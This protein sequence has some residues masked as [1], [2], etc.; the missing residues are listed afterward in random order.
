MKL[1]YLS[2]CDP[3]KPQGS[4]FLGACIV[5]GDDLLSAI[6]TAYG[7]ACNP[8][9]EVV[10]QPVPEDLVRHVG[11]QWLER[12]LTRAECAGLDAELKPH[13]VS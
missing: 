7:L 4:Q 5:A 10:G 8:G 1:W 2:F 9:G 13:A 12:L 3:D 6:Q 11:P